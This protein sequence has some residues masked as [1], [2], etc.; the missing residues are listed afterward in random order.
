MKEK[1]DIKDILNIIFLVF[2]IVLCFLFSKEI[3]KNNKG[4]TYEKINPDYMSQTALSLNSFNIPENSKYSYFVKKDSKKPKLNA[5]SY[6]VGDLDT[7]EIILSKDIDKTYPIASV[8]KLMTALVSIESKTENNLAKVSKRALSTYGENGDF[9]LNE[10]LKVSDLLY[11]LLLESSND[12]AE[13]IAEH[14]DRKKFIKNMNIKAESINMTKTTYADPSGLSE[15]NQSTVLDLFKLTGYIKKEKTELFE[16]TKKRSYKNKNHTWFSNNQ[17]LQEKEYLGGKSGFTLPAKQTVI[18]NFSLPLGKENNRP[19]SIILLQSKDRQK[20][21]FDILKYLKKNVYYGGASD[22]TKNWVEEKAEPEYEQDF[23]TLGFA[24]DI[25]LDRGVRNSVNK[26]FL[27]DY[28]ALFEKLNIIK[29]YDIMFANLEGPASDKG[30]DLGNLYSFRMNPSIIPAL[31]GAGISIVSVANNHVGDY[32]REAYI[33]TL[34]R[35]KENEIL[36]T[37]GGDLYEAENPTIIEKYGMRIGFLGFSD[38]GPRNME[39]TD[40]NAG[41]LLANNPRFKEIITN[42]SAKVDHLVVSFHF[43]D[44]YKNMHNKRQEYLAHTAVDAGAKIVIGHHPHVM[45]DTEVYKNSFIAYSLGNFIFDQKFSIETMQGMLLELKLYK[46]GEITTKKN[47]VKLNKVFQPD[48][49]ILG[50]EEIVKFKK[51]E[52]KENTENKNPPSN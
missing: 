51:E 20:D 19:I 41:L 23:V 26:N 35:L 15:K 33:D 1:L 3:N 22:Q 28:S 13:I 11:P 29:S 43:G 12:A 18:S 36:Y 40:E 48:K 10:K 6:L 9:K 44:E 4:S 8:S 27:G 38:V 31:K 46:N 34:G 24:G 7:G 52:K 30:R 14:F 25:M 42:A 32:G 37:G 49:I 47:I 50:K 17:F 16:I 45:Q 39:V 21:V 5:E 2:F